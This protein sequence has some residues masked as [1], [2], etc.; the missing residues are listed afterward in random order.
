VW[1]CH[2]RVGLV[3][4]PA[5]ARLLAFPLYRGRSPCQPGRQ[6]GTQSTDG[7]PAAVVAGAGR[8]VKDKSDEEERGAG[9]A[10]AALPCSGRP[11]PHLSPCP[12]SL[13]HHSNLLASFQFDLK[14]GGRGGRGIGSGDDIWRHQPHST[15]TAQHHDDGGGGFRQ[16]Q[17]PG[18]RRRLQRLHRR[19]LHPQEDRPPASS[20]VRRPRR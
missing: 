3:W 7:Q 8:I 11:A 12:G 4:G 19:Q 2:V 20:Q 16:H 6:P 1:T 14:R 13:L 10:C 18:A 17:G 15:G 5:R 9:T